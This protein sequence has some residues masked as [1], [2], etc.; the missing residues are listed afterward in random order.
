MNKVKLLVLSFIIFFSCENIKEKNSMN[1]LWIVKKV[2]MGEKEMTPIKRW[3]KFNKDSTQTSGNGWLQHSIG[4]WSYKK[5]AKLLVIK[6][7][8]GIVDNAEPFKVKLEKNNMIWLRKEDGNDVSV[9]LERINKI[10][11]SEANKL[12]GLWKFDSIL[13]DDKEV[14]DSINPNKKAMLFLRWDNTY[15]LHN[16][17]K[18]KKYGIFK[19]HGHRLQLDMVNYSQ[20]PKYQFY[21]F[22]IN[23]NKL[24]LKS[25]NSNKELKLT[26]I[27]Q[28][29]Q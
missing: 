25:T 11:A 24:V 23:G 12:L 8:N 20:K 13:Y 28:F 18:G 2:K 29:L 27:H 17:P 3:M 10:P 15:E 6:N 4:S 19:T 1:G 22:S 21:G 5:Q 9:F 14:S 16:Y 26:R 7:D